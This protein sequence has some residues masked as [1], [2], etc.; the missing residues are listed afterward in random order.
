V[1]ARLGERIGPALPPGLL[2]GV[3]T[4]PHDGQD[5]S[6]LLRVARRRAEATRASI[7]HRISSEQVGLLDLL[8]LP[9]L[10]AEAP[11]AT[12]LSAPRRIELSLAD[13]AALAGTVVA[14]ALRGGA[15][16]FTMAHHP[17][18]SLGAAVRASIGSARE[19]VTVHALDVRASQG[20]DIEALSVIAEHG[21]YAFIGRNQGGTVKGLH[22]A[23][24][25]FADLL[26]DRL[27]RAAGLRIFT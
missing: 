15:A 22:A 12:E 21:A 23:D 13:A 8:D 6:Q 27:G 4:F 18:L 24:P 17:N 20:D 9:A 3:S 5:L 7:V 16:L 11:P 25:L 1:F 14:D 10:S 2:V 19:N 26:A